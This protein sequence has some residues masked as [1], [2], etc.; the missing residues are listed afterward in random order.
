MKFIFEAFTHQGGREKNE[1][2]LGQ[3]IGSDW[4]CFIVADGLG[5]HPLGEVASHELTHAILH[6][7]TRFA[8]RIANDPEGGIMAL[9][10]GAHEDMCQKIKAEH[11]L[12]DAHTTLALAWLTPD[13]CLTAHVGDSRIYRVAPN[14]I[15]WRT[16]DHTAVQVLFDSGFIT[17]TDM[18][19]HP[20]QN[21]LDRTVS[22]TR[23][24]E[25][26]VIIHPPLAPEE[27][28]VL[29]TDGFWTKLL[30][31]DFVRFIYAP[32]L[33]K[34]LPLWVEKIL[35]DDPMSDNVTVQIVSCPLN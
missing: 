29:C 15:L 10:S 25:P 28:L 19:K 4:G 9:L 13:F 18:L 12:V 7:A 31:D 3:Q 27:R 1:D 24:F 14:S 33:E 8:D 23:S 21:R 17:E 5:G 35:K 34:Q 11:G 2:S 20:K 32:D 26:D 22:T 30:P 6:L 16:A